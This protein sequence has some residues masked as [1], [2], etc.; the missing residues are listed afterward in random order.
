MILGKPALMEA[1]GMQLQNIDNKVCFTINQFRTDDEIKSYRSL[2]EDGL[3]SGIEIFYPNEVSKE[4]FLMYT[5]NIHLLKNMGVEVVMHLPHGKKYDL[6]NIQESDRVFK[7]MK[8]AIDYAR[9]F[10]VKKFTL[11]LGYVAD[12]REN[13]ISRMIPILQNLCDYAYPSAIM[14]ENMPGISELGYSPDEILMII[15]KVERKNLKFIFDTGHAHVS[16]YTLT[17][18]LTKLKPYLH[19]IHFNDNNGVR[20]E[21]RRIGEG[22]IDFT[23]VFA[24][25][26]EYNELHCLE[27]LYRTVDDIKLY[28]Q[29]LSRFFKKK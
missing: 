21:H 4:A 26:N 3:I 8:D 22:T 14:I 28:Y 20:D 7:T 1:N 2:I 17:D 9:Q 16:E 24:Q 19:H 27:I 5:E 12:I 11:H 25:L 23:Q 18:Y 29:D 10:D 6:C 15:K 13:V